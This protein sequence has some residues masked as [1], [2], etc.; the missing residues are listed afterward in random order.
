M[1]E[2]WDRFDKVPPLLMLSP[3]DGRVQ[4]CVRGEV[5]GGIVAIAVYGMYRRGFICA[6]FCRKG[7]MQIPTTT[8]LRIIR[9]LLLRDHGLY[10][11]GGG[12]LPLV[13]TMNEGLL[14]ARPTIN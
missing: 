3:G 7:P 9:V 10:P 5:G 6:G 13:S 14:H 4:C 12:F 1:A 11:F 8:C 2:Y